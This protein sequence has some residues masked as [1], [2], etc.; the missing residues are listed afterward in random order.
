MKDFTHDDDICL[1]ITHFQTSKSFFPKIDYLRN[2]ENFII[3][4]KLNRPKGKNCT[5]NI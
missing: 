4:A 1:Y 2:F 5:S 3:F